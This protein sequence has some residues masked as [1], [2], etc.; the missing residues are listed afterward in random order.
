MKAN[1][2]CISMAFSFTLTLLMLFSVAQGQQ[3]TVKKPSLPTTPK[4]PTVNCSE[5]ET[6][7][8]CSSFK[9]LLEAKDKELL[10]SLSSPTSYV[11]FRPKC[12]FR[13]CRSLIPI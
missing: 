6:S 10:D 12:V 1:T 4:I 9:Q 2:S 7:K 3:T 13:R 11:C 8:A 5:A